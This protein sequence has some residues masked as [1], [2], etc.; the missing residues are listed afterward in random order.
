MVVFVVLS[1]I[2]CNFVNT[3]VELR[4]PKSEVIVQRNNLMKG[5]PIVKFNEDAKV[6]G[7][8]MKHGSKFILRNNVMVKCIFNLVDSAMSFMCMDYSLRKVDL[9][10]LIVIEAKKKVKLWEFSMNL[11]GFN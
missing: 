4:T 1:K 6:L 10:E 9:F 5:L 3:I 11:E 7:L 8:S 2:S